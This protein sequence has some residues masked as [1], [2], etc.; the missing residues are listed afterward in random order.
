MW[1]IGTKTAWLEESGLK[2]QS[3]GTMDEQEWS[4]PYE[5]LAR[6]V[7]GLRQTWPEEMIIEIFAAA[8]RARPDLVPPTPPPAR[9]AEVDTREGQS[10]ETEIAVGFDERALKGLLERAFAAAR[11][12]D[13]STPTM[14]GA[15]LA[16]VDRDVSWQREVWTYR[17][18]RE[19]RA[20]VLY[21]EREVQDGIGGPVSHPVSASF[22]L[23]G[24]ADGVAVGGTWTGR[25]VEPRVTGPPERVEAALNALRGT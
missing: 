7:M 2:V 8:A 3:G 14:L 19:R 15:S 10:G 20:F 11:I 18:E 5:D 9:R 4:Y 17:A 13:P 6:V 12:L 24:L 1:R 21:L 25:N 22:S 16:L 23:V